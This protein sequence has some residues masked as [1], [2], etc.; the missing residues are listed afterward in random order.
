MDGMWATDVEMLAVSH[1]LKVPILEAQRWQRLAPNNEDRILPESEPSAGFH[2]GFLA[3]GGGKSIGA[4]MKRGNVRGGVGGIPLPAPPQPL[5]T[6]LLM[7]IG[8][9]FVKLS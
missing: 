8:I 6:P 4:S 2:T 1:L 9:K 7:C 3:W 5:N